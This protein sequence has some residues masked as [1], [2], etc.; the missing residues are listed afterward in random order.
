M[1]AVTCADFIYEIATMRDESGMLFCYRYTV[2]QRGPKQQRLLYGFKATVGEAK[3]I[4]ETYVQI[5]A[6]AWK[7]YYAP[8]VPE[9]GTGVTA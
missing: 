1:D 5:A 8:V 2:Y 9:T 6:E 7:L 4:A 3:R